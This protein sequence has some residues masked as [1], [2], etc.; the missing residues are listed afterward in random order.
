MLT[1]RK[2]HV[3]VHRV[4]K[5]YYTHE[6]RIAEYVACKYI[7]P[8]LDPSARLRICPVFLERKQ[9]SSFD[10]HAAYRIPTP[11]YKYQHMS[12]QMYGISACAFRIIQAHAV[13]DRHAYNTS[14]QTPDSLS[15]EYPTNISK[16]ILS[17]VLP[18]LT[19]IC[20][21]LISGQDLFL[22]CGLRQVEG[23]LHLLTSV[24]P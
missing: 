19:K 23:N 18:E 11:L 17:C 1:H 21:H 12:L 2:I 8:S 22:G 24:F 16:S 4:I 3:E 14:I 5:L 6:Q 10:M 9:M 13:C 20:D 7:R 15:F